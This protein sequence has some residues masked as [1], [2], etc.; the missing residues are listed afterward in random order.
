MPFMLLFFVYSLLK[1]NIRV[2]FDKPI[3]AKAINEKQYNELCFADSNS[4]CTTNNNS[5]TNLSIQGKLIDAPD[6]SYVYADD[7]T[8]II[9]GITP[10]QKNAIY[11]VDKETV[12]QYFNQTDE[13]ECKSLKQ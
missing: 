10:N 12:L 8:W 5:T 4:I 1:T 2:F 11:I 3:L 7:A 6:L 9:V 13:N